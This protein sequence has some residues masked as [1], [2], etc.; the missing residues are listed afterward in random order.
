VIDLVGRLRHRLIAAAL[1]PLTEH[2]DLNEAGV[3]AYAAALAKRGI[4]GIA[5]WA[6]TGRAPYLQSHQRR[7]VFRTFRRV[8][9]LP[10]IA[11]IAAPSGTAATE[12]A[13]L[14]EMLRAAAE[15]AQLGADGLMVFPPVALRDA[16][17][18]EA[19]TLR[20]HEQVAREA[21]LPV[22]LF[23]LHSGAGGFPYPE[24][25]LRD[26]LAIPQTVGIKLATL[27]SAIACQDV[28]RIVREEFADKLA[29]TG[30]DR[31]FG[32]SLMWGANAA[33]VGIAGAVPELSLT[34]L[35]SWVAQ[36]AP[37]FLAASGRL[38]RFARATFC[39]PIEG[40]IQRMLWA[41]AWEGLIPEEL[42]YDPHGPKLPATERRQ[43]EEALEEVIPQR[44]TRPIR[45]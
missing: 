1:T 10:I 19:A 42:A 6:H 15:A 44:A 34:V 4:G 31:M 29:I 18:R 28:L 33:L 27:D 43:V 3:E 12:E 30:E 35:E 39:A 17:D 11:G 21:D 14:E 25:L 5:V 38:D 9:D 16:P 37:G 26:L 36:D 22:I 45:R 24:G 2:G 13:V 8:T 7:T 41:A 23:Y 32:P 40:Y 20:I